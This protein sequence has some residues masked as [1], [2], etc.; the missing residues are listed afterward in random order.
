MIAKSTRNVSTGKPH[1]PAG[2]QE[3]KKRWFACHLLKPTSY[4]S[5]GAGEKYELAK[6]T[7]VSRPGTAPSSGIA[8]MTAPQQFPIVRLPPHK[9]DK[10]P[11]RPPRPDSGVM[12]DVSAWLDDSINKPA[13][14]LMG[15]LSYW[16]E[17][18]VTNTCESGEIQYAKPIVRE[19]SCD[20]PST[21]H[22]QQ[23][24]SFCRRAKRMQVRMPSFRRTA[25]QQTTVQKK[26]NRRSASAPLITFPY[27]D[28]E[29]GSAP[30]FL[31]RFGSA[32]RTPTRPPT[33]TARTQT[34]K[35]GGWFGEGQSSLVS[36]HSHQ[37]SPVSARFGK[38]E[39]NVEHHA[40]LAYGQYAG[41]GHNLLP[42]LAGG[43]MLRED[44]MGS[45]SDAPTYFSGPPPPSYRSRTASILTTSSFGCIDGMNGEQRE[46]SQQRAAQKNSSM[47]GKFR[48]FAQ[49]ARLAK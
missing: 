10:A 18:S 2:R 40:N 1:D 7:D 25:S 45:L 17:G 13:S 49:R 27:E 26:I 39:W 29:E 15:G 36:L 22:S 42:V 34:A 8:T 21:S 20:R 38:P 23:L 19:P 14:P 44:S 4:Q 43:F 24:K 9:A 3:T 11:I 32:R 35:V 31:T 37:A 33:A 28:A 12:R 48:K 46:L 5:N 30:A 16:R 41:I 47:K 6:E